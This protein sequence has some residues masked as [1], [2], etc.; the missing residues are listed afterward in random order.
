M[1]IPTIAPL[2]SAVPPPEPTHK[3]EFPGCANVT[4][5]SQTYSYTGSCAM[6][7]PNIASFGCAAGHHFAC[8]PQH[9]LD[10][11]LSCLK[12]HQVPAHNTALQQAAIT[13]DATVL[14]NAQAASTKAGTPA[15]TGAS[16]S[17]P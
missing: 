15:V 8:C 7:G 6:P 11:F 2:A 17:L 3:C 16:V 10:V 5:A 12:Y 1:S 9:A 13:L 14:S 4:P